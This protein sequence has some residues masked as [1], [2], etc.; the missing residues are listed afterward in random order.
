MIH[1]DFKNKIKLKYKKGKCKRYM[2]NAQYTSHVHA[3][4]FFDVKIK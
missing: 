3:M 4:Y 1:N 2:Y